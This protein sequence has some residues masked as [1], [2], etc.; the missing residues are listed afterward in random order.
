M[1]AVR[2]DEMCSHCLLPREQ[3]GPLLHSPLA[4][5]CHNCAEQ[6]LRQFDERG[7]SGADDP[8]RL[9]PQWQG[10]D[11]ERL[12]RR[13]SDIARSRDGVE[14]YLVEW[15]GRARERGISWARIGEVLGMTRQSA[16]ER[17]SRRI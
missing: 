6:A 10:L 4:T 15:V 3:V 14:D 8:R 1:S 17:F 11:D 2:S 13:L 16:W 5:I 9:V 12:L 7:V